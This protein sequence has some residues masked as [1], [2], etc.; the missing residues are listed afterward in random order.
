MKTRCCS[1]SYYD[2]DRCRNPWGHVVAAGTSEEIKMQQ[3]RNLAC[4]LSGKKV[5]EIPWKNRE[6]KWKMLQIIGAKG[7]I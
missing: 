6:S 2:M 7:I 1:G 3:F 5:I 4:I